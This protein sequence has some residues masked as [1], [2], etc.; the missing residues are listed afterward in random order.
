MPI[1]IKRGRYPERLGTGASEGEGTIEDAGALL[2]GGPT[3]G[4]S[5]EAMGIRRAMRL[6]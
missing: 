5:V 6:G 4:T 2:P 3:E 1:S